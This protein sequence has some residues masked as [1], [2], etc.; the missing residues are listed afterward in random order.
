MGVRYLGH[1]VEHEGLG[2]EASVSWYY[3]CND[4]IINHSFHYPGNYDLLNIEFAIFHRRTIL[5]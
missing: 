3:A 2:L 1:H 5:L 4:A